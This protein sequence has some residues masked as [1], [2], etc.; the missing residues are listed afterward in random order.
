MPVVA[1]AV[2][3]VLVVII[4]LGIIGAAF[5]AFM[6]IRSEQLMY[7]Y[8]LVLHLFNSKLFLRIGSK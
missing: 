3:I 6:V 4:V 1:I 7:D 8:G 5:C 2:P